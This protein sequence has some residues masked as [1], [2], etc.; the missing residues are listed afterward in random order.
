MIWYQEPGVTFLHGDVIAELR[1]LP[2]ACVDVIC[3][4]PPYFGQRDYH[5]APSV[6]GGDDSCDH[7]WG[8][9]RTRRI[10]NDST[11]RGA[12]ETVTPF[13]IPTGSFETQKKT[14]VSQGQF[15]GLCDAW[16][17]CLGN[18]PDVGRYVAHLVAVFREVR[19]VMK[20]TAVLFC[21]LGDAYA[22]SGGA[23]KAGHANPG[24]SK[25][26][27]RDGATSRANPGKSDAE[28]KGGN[29]DGLGAIPGY[30]P[31]DLM[32][33][34]ARVAIAL[35]DDGWWLR[36]SIIWHKPS[37][38]PESARD[39]VTNDY[40]H[41][42]MLT[43]N[44]K[45]FFDA[46]AIREASGA[47]RRAV[48]SI[49]PESY[50]G[51]HYAAWPRE[52]AQRCILAGSSEYGCCASCGA[53]WARGGV[54]GWHPTCKCGG[55]V[56]PGLVCDPFL[57]SGTTAAVAMALGRQVIGIDRSEK[58]LRLARQRILNPAPPE[59]EGTDAG[60]VQ[61]GLFAEVGL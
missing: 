6:W 8:E 61:L 29:R 34:P 54:T 53:P 10:G 56:V 49:N 35:C 18:E 38:L 13:R 22:G 36:S 2:D 46:D 31:K 41:I 33:I 23:H 5:I 32:L 55:L 27:A 48:W 14:A 20:K 16:R 30:K 24:I 25:S 28:N 3:T 45:Y 59:E 12:N 47:N 42:F 15:C 37:T 4:S 43:K 1:T 21:N 11:N 58:Y 26:S 7:V 9:E 50:T 39:R 60:D 44:Q 51:A 40:E 19:R 17:G 52:I 57:G